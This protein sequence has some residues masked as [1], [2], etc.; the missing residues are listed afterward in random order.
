M[1]ERKE[2]TLAFRVTPGIRLK[3]KNYATKKKISDSEV[4]RMALK[5]FLKNSIAK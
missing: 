1:I 3:I 4:V 5:K 2:I